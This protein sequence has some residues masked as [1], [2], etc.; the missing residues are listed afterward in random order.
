MKKITNFFITT[1]SIIVILSFSGC[2]LIKSNKVEEKKVTAISRE[3]LDEGYYV[4]VGDD[5]Y[6]PISDYGLTFSS[7]ATKPKSSRI[8]WWTDGDKLVPTLRKETDRLIYFSKKQRLS[9]FSLEEMEDYGY[10]IGISNISYD[11]KLH[12]YYFNPYNTQSNSDANRYSKAFD[13]NNVYINNINDATNI[14]TYISRSG[15][16]L[17]LEKGKG[18]DLGIYYGTVYKQIT[19][20][21]DTRIMASYKIYTLNKYTLTK[22]GYQVIELPEELPSG[23][24]C[25]DGLGLFYYD[26]P[27]KDPDY[28]NY[29]GDNNNIYDD[30]I[31]GFNSYEENTTGETTSQNITN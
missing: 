23:Y 14:E 6:Y 2:K 10:S 25:V 7:I 20:I 26:N 3:N 19:L 24:Y 31:P 16:L 18:Y 8:A 15:T 4:L 22:D 28:S 27:D 21:A 9:L 17:G 13:T 30:L 5:K 1:I 11:E 29:E 12:E